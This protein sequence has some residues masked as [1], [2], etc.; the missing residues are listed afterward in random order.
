[1]EL[2]LEKGLCSLSHYN[3][4]KQLHALVDTAATP[5]DFL[6]HVIR[7][8]SASLESIAKVVAVAS[9]GKSEAIEEL[10]KTVA[11]FGNLQPQVY[12]V[13]FEK[14]LFDVFIDSS[15]SKR[16]Y[17][18]LCFETEEVPLNYRGQKAVLSMSSEHAQLC[19]LSSSTD[20]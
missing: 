20:S 11:I 7:T 16:F 4:G 14:V 10:P 17:G 8:L 1:M 15:A 9:G 6:R 18:V 13:V 19:V 12:S 3:N 2:T 5:Y